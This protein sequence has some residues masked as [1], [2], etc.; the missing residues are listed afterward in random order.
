VLPALPSLAVEAVWPLIKKAP[1]A[2]AKAEIARAFNTITERKQRPDEA[3][4]IKVHFLS[5]KIIAEMA[6]M[7]KK[8]AFRKLSRDCAITVFIEERMPP[9]GK[10]EGIP[11]RVLY[12]A[13]DK[14]GLSKSAIRRAYSRVKKARE[15]ARLQP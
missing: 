8:P 9:G 2:P 12:D 6:R 10:R 3:D 7:G 4:F 11:K 14:F 13:M 1:H 15:K 5:F